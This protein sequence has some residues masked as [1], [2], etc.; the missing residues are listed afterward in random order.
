M[1]TILLAALILTSIHSF[2]QSH[3]SNPVSGIEAITGRWDIVGT[4]NEG[5]LEII[6]DQEIIVSYGGEKR[7]ITGFKLDFSKNPIWFDF[8]VKGNGTEVMRI[9]SIMEVISEDLIKWQ[10]FVDEERSAH[11]TSE[12]GELFYLKRVKMKTVVTFAH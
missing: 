1:K 2:S 7:T 9:N 5:W 3:S 10:V 6:N 4:K 8:T 12:R 11:F